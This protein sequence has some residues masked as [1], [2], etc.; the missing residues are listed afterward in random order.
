MNKCVCSKTPQ[1]RRRKGTQAKHIIGIRNITKG[2][3]GSSSIASSQIGAAARPVTQSGS[4]TAER[5]RSSD[6]P[7]P[8]AR[9]LSLSPRHTTVPVVVGERPRL[10]VTRREGNQ[11][12]RPRTRNSQAKCS[13]RGSSSVLKITPACMPP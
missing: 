3:Q 12:L 13:A 2:R 6:S 9:N 5:A 10:A 4:T 1:T 8:H 7:A 11:W